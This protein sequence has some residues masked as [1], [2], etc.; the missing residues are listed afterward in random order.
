MPSLFDDHYSKLAVMRIAAAKD[1]SAINIEDARVLRKKLDDV[2]KASE[3]A[4]SAAARRAARL[5]AALAD[6]ARQPAIQYAAGALRRLGLDFVS[7]AD[8]NKLTEAMRE[9]NLD[10]T[11]RIELKRVLSDLGVIA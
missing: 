2:I 5:D 7:A 1:D 9:R 11:T 4:N 3:Q 10:V 8:M 6:P